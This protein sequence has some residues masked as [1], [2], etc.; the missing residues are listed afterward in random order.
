MDRL[1]FVHAMI[2]AYEI[3]EKSRAAGQRL[4]YNE[5]AVLFAG[6]VRLAAA[7]DSTL[8]GRL[9]RIDDAGALHVEAFDEQAP[10]AEPAYLAPELLSADAPDKNDP[11]VQVYAAG[12][13]GY[14]L[15]T[16]RL[17]PPPG[18]AAG[19]ELTGSLGDVVRRALA[20][21]RRGRIE[22][23]RQLHEAVEEVQPRPPS[24]GERTI[25]SALRNRFSRT[26][27]EKEAAAKLNDRLHQLETQVAQLGKAQA[28]LEASQRESSETIERFE[29]GQTRADQAGRR[30][31]S[32]V[33]P[34]MAVAALTSAAVF[35]AAWAFGLLAIPPRSGLLPMAN[36]PPPPLEPVEV[37]PAARDAAVAEA[38]PAPSGSR[39]VVSEPPPAP[40]DAKPV[41]AEAKPGPA[42]A[43][44]APA[45]ATP[46]P[47]EA[48][49]VTAEAP[50]D[51]GTVVAAENGNADAGLAANTDAGAP[52]PTPATASP[53]ARRQPAANSHA[54]MLHALA[55]SQVRRG[56]TALEEG[57]ADEALASFK[58]A[59]ENEPT[60]AVAFRGLG[61]AYAMQGHDAEA[62]QAYDKYLRLTPKALDAPGIRQSMVELRARAK[63]GAK[64]E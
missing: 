8:R 41:P 6:A 24:E 49:P 36:A 11:K 39:R 58:A 32:V 40:A 23:L 22:D 57:N 44:P 15:L 26:S 28:R 10:E 17:A 27:P 29:M 37:A 5:A 42:E 63:A 53:P 62:L 7:N 1:Q 46:P 18:H 13:L 51:A 33:A 59:L 48:R 30:R 14:E 3:L 38:K 55:L 16:G 52:A 50:A 35:A 12:V 60:I 61:M 45:E 64:R 31:Q 25:L 54:A 21:D 47:A 43:K 56:E 2:S 19:P 9:V 34:A 20:V 4:P